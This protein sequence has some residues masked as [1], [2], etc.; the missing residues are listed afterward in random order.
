[1]CNFDW[2][3]KKAWMLPH[4]AHLTCVTQN[5][6]S[7][8]NSP[9]KRNIYPRKYIRKNC[10]IPAKAGIQMINN[11]PRKWGDTMVLSADGTTS[12]STKLAN[13]ASKVAG[14]SQ[15]IFY[16]WIPASAGMTA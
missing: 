3:V 11:P 14:Y 7:F 8:L 16:H 2:P 10:V 6:T 13:N 12:H 15:S 5:C 1:L 4:P 9:D